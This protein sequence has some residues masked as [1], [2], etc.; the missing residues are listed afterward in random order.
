[1]LTFP[2][3]R[4]RAFAPAAH[5]G[6]WR[7]PGRIQ[8]DAVP[9]PALHVHRV[10]HDHHARHARHARR[11]HRGDP[12][13]FLRDRRDHLRGL[14]ARRAPGPLQTRDL[15]G[16]VVRSGAWEG[17]PRHHAA[18]SWGRLPRRRSLGSRERLPRRRDGGRHRVSR[19]GSAR[20]ASEHRLASPT[21]C[22]RA[23][24]APMKWASECRL[25]LLYPVSEPTKPDAE[26]PSRRSPASLPPGASARPPS[27]YGRRPA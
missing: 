6:W 17:A 10:G 14:R 2:L 19:G 16:S 8:N 12:D 3:A 24:A 25:L 7:R 20:C 9:D 11:S 5:R 21:L 26:P 18:E 4:W 23:V 22:C 1:V 13:P 15:Q 27:R